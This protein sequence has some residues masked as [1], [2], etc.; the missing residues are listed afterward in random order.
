MYDTQAPPPEAAL[1][2][3]LDRPGTD[4]WAA[5]DSLDELRELAESAGVSVLDKLTQKRDAPSAPTFVGKGKVAE[6][7]ALCQK[8][9]AN[10]VIF[11]DDLSPAQGRNLGEILGPTIKV[12]DRT[13]L[14]LD[15][16]AQRILK[17]IA[18]DLQ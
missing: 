16:F 13:E 8:L 6:I 1:L 10:T 14:I 2:I 7:A 12:I 15:I 11:D 4:R 5:N 9:A 3:G 17:V 18:D